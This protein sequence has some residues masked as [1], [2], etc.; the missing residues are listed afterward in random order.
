MSLK[1]KLMM[2][3]LLFALLG[4]N[5]V[6]AGAHNHGDHQHHQ[7][8]VVSPFDGTKEVRSLHCLLR[9][10]TG[11]SICPHSSDRGQGAIIAAEC[12]GKTSGNN[13][14]ITSFSSELAELQFFLLG[15]NSPDETLTPAII[16]SYHRF[17]DS[18][19]PPPLV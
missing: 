6:F 3:V 16:L 10:H 18:L 14:G 13:S 8:S 15:H 11:H 9:G 19:D 2:L 17:A 1:V 4:A 5:N 7:T 12:G